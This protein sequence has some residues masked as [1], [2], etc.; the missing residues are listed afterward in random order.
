MFRHKS[1]WTGLILTFGVG[2]VA[3]ASLALLFAPM[4]GKR[5]Q[6]KVAGLTDKVMDKVDDLQD[7]VRR[8]ATA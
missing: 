8:M 5:M 4:T 1:A 3:G 2:L 7:T 6:K